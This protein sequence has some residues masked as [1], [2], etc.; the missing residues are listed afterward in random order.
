LP[1]TKEYEILKEE[2]EVP[3]MAP[4]SVIVAK[5]KAFGP[6]YGSNAT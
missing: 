2:T 3:E 6:V 1:L 5:Y 4:S